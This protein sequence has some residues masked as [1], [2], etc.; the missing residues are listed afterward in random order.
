M[1][2]MTSNS[3]ALFSNSSSLLALVD[4]YYSSFSFSALSFFNSSFS[5]SI[6]FSWVAISYWDL[7]SSCFKMFSLLSLSPSYSQRQALDVSWDFRLSILKSCF[8]LTSTSF[9]L[10]HYLYFLITVYNFTI[11]SLASF[12]C[13][14]NLS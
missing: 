12:S 3:L 7:I 11:S 8:C 2:D 1:L 10:Y 14:F 13:N 6:I 9:I 4:L 5:L